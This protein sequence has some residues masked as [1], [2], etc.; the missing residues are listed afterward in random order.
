M[1]DP[2]PYREGEPAP[3]PEYILSRIHNKVDGTE[4]MAWINPADI[5]RTAPIRHEDLDELLP[6]MRWQWKHLSDLATFCRSFEDWELGF[7]RD[8]NPGG[9]VA[10][11]NRVTYALLEFCRRNP[12]VPREV[13]FASINAISN[14]QG[15]QVR[16]AKVRE[17]LTDFL[18][19]APESM[20]DV[21][22][23]TEDGTFMAGPS[24]LR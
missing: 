1:N 19:H 14:G 17:K 7:L 20:G 11:W 3:G 22:N 6:V 23:F 4:R 2:I 18:Q 9:Q 10:H 16:P 24:H 13:V 15:E 12:G 21:A 8:T 5:V